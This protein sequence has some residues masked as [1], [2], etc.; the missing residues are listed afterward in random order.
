MAE[1]SSALPV[2]ES[3]TAP[4]AVVVDDDSDPD[5]DDLDGMYRVLRTFIVP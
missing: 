3:K 4:P 5:F 1:K 2:A